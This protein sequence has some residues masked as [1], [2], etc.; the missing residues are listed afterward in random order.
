LGTHPV[1][2]VVRFLLEVSALV[3]LGLWG[4]HRRVDRW[5]I[6]VALAIPLLAAALWGTF[7]VPNDPSRSGSAP[8]PIPGLLRL[9]LELGFFAC[10]TWALYDL[11]FRTLAAIFGGAVVLHYLL[12]YDRIRWLVEQ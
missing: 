5:Q 2:L 11:G 12:S 7:A 8:V 1:N 6:L 10:A 3:T 4:W 9:A